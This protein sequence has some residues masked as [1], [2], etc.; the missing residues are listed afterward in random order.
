MAFYE[1]LSST[2]LEKSFPRCV[3]E[4]CMVQKAACWVVPPFVAKKEYEE[5]GCIFCIS[6]V[7]G[8][9]QWLDVWWFHRPTTKQKILPTEFWDTTACKIWISRW[10]KY[11]NIYI[12][13]SM[14]WYGTYSMNKYH[15]CF[16][17]DTWVNSYDDYLQERQQVSGGWRW[18]GD[19]FLCPLFYLLTLE[20][21]EYTTHTNIFY[22]WGKKFF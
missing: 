20:P 5:K 7:L 8:C 13:G 21:C 14:R 4:K 11:E 18:E 17:E 2:L 1:G 6:S 12:L 22:I 16:W 19:F 10:L 9:Q 3:S 15:I